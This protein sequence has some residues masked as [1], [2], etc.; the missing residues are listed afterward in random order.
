[1]S[2]PNIDAQNVKGTSILVRDLTMEMGDDDD[3]G[4]IDDNV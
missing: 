1:M 4:R 2:L 3:K